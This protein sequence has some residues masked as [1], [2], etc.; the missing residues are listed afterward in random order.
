VRQP[1]AA[2]SITVGEE[3]RIRGQV[4]GVGFR[5][6]VWRRALD[7]AL[8]GDVCND[9]H[10]V[11]I[12]VWGEPNAVDRFVHAVCTEPPPLARIDS[13]ERRP[14]TG[15][16]VGFGFRIVASVG[17]MADTAIVPDA[18]T[19]A[20]CAAE[21]LLPGSRRFGYPFTNC[22]HCGPR[23]TILRGIPY[24]RENT[25]LAEFE[26]CAEC[27]ADY[28]DPRDRRFHA[29][30]IACPHCGPR[31]WVEPGFDEDPLHAA[32]ELL[33]AGAI[34]AIKGVGGFH[35][36]CDAT[37][38]ETVAELR[39]RKHRSRK[40][41]A[42]MAPTIEVIARYCSV[43]AAERALLSSAAAPIVLCDIDGRQR[44]PDSVAPGLRTL[45]FMLPYSPLHHLLLQGFETP[46]VL[47][48][49]NVSDAPQC[50]DNADARD[51][52]AG[53]AD[54]WLL[55]DREIVNR[56]DDSVV[57]VCA[58]AQRILRRARGYAPAALALPDGFADAPAVLAMGG[59]LKNTFG[60]AKGGQALLSQHQGDLEDSRTFDDYRR[61]LDLYAGIFDH[62][63][64]V[65][66]VDMHPDY[67][68]TKVGQDLAGAA[69]IA[70]SSVQHHHAH[71][72]SCMAENA[73]A[74]K[75]P[76]V[77]GVALDG[78]GMGERGELWGGEFLLADYRGFRRVA[79]LK[80]V[81]LLGGAQA[82]R[83]PWRNAYAHIDEAMGSAA[84]RVRY[85]QLGLARFFER[86]SP[87]QL[88]A[89]LA[90]GVGSPRASSCGRLFD[91]VAAAI[92]I[93]RERMSY[94]GE[95]AIELE[96]LASF[97][98][99]HHDESGYPFELFDEDTGLGVLDPAPM[100][101]V[102]LDDLSRGVAR[103][104][105]AA[106]FH[107]GL[108]HAIA[109]TVE[110]HA[111]RCGTRTVALT[112]GAFQN[113]ILLEDVSAA[114]RMWDYSVLTHHKVPAG[115]GG[116]ALGQAAIA[117]ARAIGGASRCA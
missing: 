30:P 74:L 85:P 73:V 37:N 8:V 2:A 47:T 3:I 112:G 45:G 50:I 1:N 43:S 75:A 35:I 111:R 100:W 69:S 104:V 115:D 63:P 114:L 18:T 32:R 9:S 102:L 107:R 60:L 95:A 28:E 76:P 7:Y 94:E 70:V 88:D 58:G 116:L 41:F 22:T 6:A 16:P 53:I 10:G 39:A 89:M 20:E 64:Q 57:R 17:G 68:S 19:C 34:V 82:M 40:P 101:R 77:L 91:A 110:R 106:R 42:L 55:H 96:A 103:R 71:I 51:R 113:R 12:R 29:Q 46:I 13:M 5:P 67:L 72:A 31:V 48:S 21:T 87:E 78:L 84:F 105:I 90:T 62:Q 26:M 44:L 117:A 66:A 15:P 27:R 83:Q 92:N 33:R 59:E 56:V 109:T 93:C 36:A 99:R 14:L 81:A 38:A 65:V 4:Q 108:A 79:R 23:L 54:A 61:S 49:G 25:S 86:R 80:P 24:D 11:L 52:L 97:H 98:G